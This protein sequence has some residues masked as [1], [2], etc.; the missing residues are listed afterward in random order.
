MNPSDNMNALVN[1][2]KKLSP[3]RA[4]TD[5]KVQFPLVEG[6]DSRTQESGQS[7][8]DKKNLEGGEQSNKSSNKHSLSST[9]G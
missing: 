5:S 9:H 6:G 8:K 2:E 1:V 4:T 7:K 3:L